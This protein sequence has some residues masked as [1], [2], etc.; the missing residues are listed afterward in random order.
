M[1]AQPAVEDLD[2]TVVEGIGPKIAA[3]LDAAGVN[4]VY[5]LAA[6]SQDELRGILHDASLSADPTTWPKQAAM[7]VAGNM[8]ELK[9]YQD[10][11]QGGREV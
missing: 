4:S 8:D 5:K 1:D 9:A 10:K 3:A 7:V 11:L 2:L 6:V